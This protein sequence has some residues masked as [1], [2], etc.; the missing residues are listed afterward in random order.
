MYFRASWKKASYSL[1]SKKPD[2][3]LS[4]LAKILPQIQKKAYLLMGLETSYVRLQVPPHKNLDKAETKIVASGVVVVL[5]NFFVA[6]ALSTIDLLQN[7]AS[8][9]SHCYD[10][11]E[12]WKCCGQNQWIYDIDTE[13]AGMMRCPPTFHS[14]F[15]MCKAF[16]ETATGHINS[17]SVKNVQTPVERFKNVCS[18]IRV[19]RW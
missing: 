5:V 9:S 6:V 17:K 10:T 18:V 8:A 15:A 1:P 3:S 16:Y 4:S 11:K 19:L 7:L 12:E 2:L 13:R 14:P